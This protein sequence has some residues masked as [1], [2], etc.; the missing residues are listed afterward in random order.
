MK[1]YISLNPGGHS[2]SFSYMSLDETFSL[3]L[4]SCLWL[5]RRGCGQRAG[6]EHDHRL[7]LPTSVPSRWRLVQLCSLASLPW[8]EW[9]SRRSV[10]VTLKSTSSTL[11]PVRSSAVQSRSDVIE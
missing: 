10:L 6:V 7:T 3:L 11:S 5:G 8:K 2:N 1:S 9:V 4:L